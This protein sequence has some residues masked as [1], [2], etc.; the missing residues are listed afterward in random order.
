MMLVSKELS[1]SENMQ[2]NI[3][4]SVKFIYDI[5]FYQIILLIYMNQEKC[6]SMQSHKNIIFLMSKTIG[7]ITE[8][9]C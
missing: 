6:C 3:F 8:K 4:P 5:L 2:A 1:S 7:D 9:S